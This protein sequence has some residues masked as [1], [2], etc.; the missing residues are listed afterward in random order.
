MVPAAAGA[1]ALSCAGRMLGLLR[2]LIDYGQELVRTVQQQTVATTLFTVAV[3]FGTAD[4]AL[5]L[6]RIT[7]GLRLASALEARLV[8]RPI[9]PDAKPAPVRP[10]AVPAP[11]RPDAVPAL[12]QPPA[13]G[14]T[15]ADRQAEPRPRLPEMPTAGEIAAALRHRPAAASS[16]TSA[17][18][19]ASCR[20]TRCGTR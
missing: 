5:I 6:A 3:N 8:S 4:I 13:E 2:K 17:A 20:P 15:R 9:R 19:S 11:I 18:T 10:D 1:P 7:R 14:A 12:V 16:P